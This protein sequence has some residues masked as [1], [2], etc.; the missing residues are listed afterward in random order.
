[1]NILSGDLM[2]TSE[3]INQVQENITFRVTSAR[4]MITGIRGE[5]EMS[6][7]QRRRRI[8]ENRLKLIGMGPD[9]DMSASDSQTDEVSGTVG[10]N[11]TPSTSNTISQGSTSG[12]NIG[13]ESSNSTSHGVPSMSETQMG[14]KGRA[15]DH[16][17]DT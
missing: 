9:E 16:G 7:L 17:F 10:E 5:S 12:R 3:L 1:M 2:D 14:T 8:R 11:F 15:E 6:P 13:S 4:D